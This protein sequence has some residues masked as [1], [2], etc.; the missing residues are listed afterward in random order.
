MSGDNQ[1]GRAG[2]SLRSPLVVVVTN[3]AGVP[4]PGVT[5]EFAVTSGDAALSEVQSITDSQ[6]VASCRVILGPAIGSV[7][8]AASATGLTGSPVNFTAMSAR[9]GLGQL[10]SQ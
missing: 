1:A 4:V 10:L 8:V 9:R 6:G 2:Q 3:A 7:T 5:V